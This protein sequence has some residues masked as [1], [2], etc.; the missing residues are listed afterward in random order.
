[1]SIAAD[2]DLFHWGYRTSVEQWLLRVGDAKWYIDSDNMME[3]LPYY[4]VAVNRYRAIARLYIDGAKVGSEIT[5]SAA[6]IDIDRSGLIVG[7]EQ[8]TLGGSF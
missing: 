6:V 4:H 5:V 7:Q 3:D 8:D 2:A 1:M